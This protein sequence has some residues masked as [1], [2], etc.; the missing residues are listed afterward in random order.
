MD[1]RGH[2]KSGKP[3]IP[4][5]Y[6]QEMVDDV[7]RLLDHLELQRAHVVG[8]S[9]GAEITLKM[10]SQYPARVHSAVLAGSGWSDDNVYESW[11]LLAESFER[12]EGLRGL[13]EWATPP[14]Q[15]RTAEEVEEFEQWNQ[16][17]IAQQDTQ[18]LAALCRNYAELQELRI[19]KDELR[20]V[21]IPMLGVAGEFDVERPLLERMSGVAP[22]FRM[23]VLSGLGH[24]GPEFF[25]AL[26]E[27]AFSFFRGIGSQEGDRLTA[28][29]HEDL[30]SWGASATG[31]KPKRGDRT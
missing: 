10:A 15:T 29:T 1:C 4:S 2:G 20:V 14:G 31:I 30:R 21:R 9:M 19:T 12:G 27:H 18:A 22:D 25:R 17:V 13:F 16:T 5:A 26:A 11:R 8:H 24:M 6:G 28:R 23:I 7:V 3:H